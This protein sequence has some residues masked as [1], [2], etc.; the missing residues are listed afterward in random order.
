MLHIIP[1][2]SGCVV[3]FPQDVLL[4]TVKQ[5]HQLQH[6]RHLHHYT[7]SAAATAR[8]IAGPPSLP[9]LHAI[10]DSALPGATPFAP[11]KPFKSSPVPGI[12]MVWV[13]H[14]TTR[15][16][17]SRPCDWPR[18]AIC[19]HLLPRHIAFLAPG[20]RRTAEEKRELV[21]V[22][23][24]AAVCMFPVLRLCVPGQKDRQGVCL[25]VSLFD[26]RSALISQ[27]RFFTRRTRYHG[28]SR[29][30]LPG[31]ISLTASISDLTRVDSGG[32]PPST[33]GQLSQDCDQMTRRD[34]STWVPLVELLPL[35]PGGRTERLVI[36]NISW[37]SKCR[38]NGSSRTRPCC[39]SWAHAEKVQA[40]AQ[41]TCLGE[42]GCLRC[43]SACSSDGTVDISRGC[44]G[45]TSHVQASWR[46]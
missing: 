30:V 4:P 5:H 15:R 33:S 16:L 21:L 10:P 36:A 28:A 11:C 26:S 46:L 34:W 1:F 24:W 18:C 20:P 22:I 35:E 6:H 8:T 3:F 31:R 9:S 29:S 40:F 42:P 2:F 7:S 44:P 43:D 17:A 25:Q 45:Q 23:M 39:R 32:G 27:P 12:S 41:S 37:P 19:G 13:K 38:W 14:G